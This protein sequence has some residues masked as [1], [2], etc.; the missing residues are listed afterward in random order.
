MKLLLDAV[1]FVIIGYYCIRFIQVLIRMSSKIIFPITPEERA[2]IRKQPDK[3]LDPP[4][5]SK[6]K[7]GIIIYSIMLLFIISMYFIGLTFNEINWSIYLL[8]FTPLTTSSNLLNLFAVTRDGIMS[9]MRFVPWDKMKSYEFVRIDLNHKYYG[10]SKEVNNKYELIIQTKS[11][12]INCIVT[13]DE[14]KERLEN[15]LNQHAHG[16]DIETGMTTLYR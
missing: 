15:I 2:V 5:Y 13:S 12:P 10:F 16:T 4:T 11:F 7:V 9:G 3:V 6:Q 14:M 8:V 1:F